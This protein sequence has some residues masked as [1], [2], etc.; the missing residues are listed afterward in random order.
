MDQGQGPFPG[1]SMISQMRTPSWGSQPV[2]LNTRMPS[3]PQPKP[4]TPDAPTERLALKQL[5]ELGA[6]LLALDGDFIN[7]LIP[8][9]RA[10][11]KALAGRV[12]ERQDE[13]RQEFDKLTG[14]G[15]KALDAVTR[16]QD[17]KDGI[18]EDLNRVITRLNGAK[19]RLQ[20]VRHAKPSDASFPT[21]AEYDE[22]ETR[23]NASKAEADAVEAE[24][25]AL[26]SD[27]RAKSV[28]ITFAKQELNRIRIERDSA[29]RRAGIK[30]AGESQDVTAESLSVQG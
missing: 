10:I 3:A 9:D 15:R 25:D 22:W 18:R 5:D 13:A 28:E 17:E 14:E 23:L 1:K 6:T 27:I 11:R 26:R 16:L 8:F 21:R 7:A 24:A 30:P 2:I 29:R 4:V 19:Q 12:R 20:V